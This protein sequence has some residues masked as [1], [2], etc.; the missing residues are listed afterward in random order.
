MEI[1]NFNEAMERKNNVTYQSWYVDGM[2]ALSRIDRKDAD[3]I[4]QFVI[5][6]L[7]NRTT[8]FLN[9]NGD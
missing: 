3:K 1:I 2:D 7:L 5:G 6:Y 9:R 4:V 8:I